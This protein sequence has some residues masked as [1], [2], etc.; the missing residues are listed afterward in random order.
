MYGGRFCRRF[1]FFG[2][3]FLFCLR[4]P[5]VSQRLDLLPI[6]HHADTAGGITPMVLVVMAGAVAMAA[7]GLVL[8][9]FAL[10]R[11]R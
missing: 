8:L 4:I 7:G 10:Q 2:F 5:S 1:T 9:R 6:S 11:S 3:S